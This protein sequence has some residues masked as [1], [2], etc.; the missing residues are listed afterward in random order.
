ML[1]NPFANGFANVLASEAISKS[2]NLLVN[3]AQ[4]TLTS[5]VHKGVYNI[6][7]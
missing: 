7:N 6:V 5:K 1:V 3:L 4:V 2:F